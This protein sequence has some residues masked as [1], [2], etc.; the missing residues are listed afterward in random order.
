MVP[1]NAARA[2]ARIGLETGVAAASPHRLILMLFDGAIAAT[3]D[4]AAQ[5][6]ENRI[7]GKGKAISNAIR[8]IEE[9]LKASLDPKGGGE[10]AESLG[11]LYDYMSRRL[12]LSSLR[13]DVAGLAEV[14]RLLTELR[15]AWAAIG[16]SPEATPARARAQ[17][18]TVG[19]AAA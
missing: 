5:L 3:A 12:L 17:T 1:N 10:I 9:G 11:E 2:Y 19:Q 4:A 8:I 14:A 6:A 13:N 7:A 16:A 15:E 18:T